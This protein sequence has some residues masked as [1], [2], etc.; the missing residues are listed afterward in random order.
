[1]IDNVAQVAYQRRIQLNEA[2]YNIVK[3][4]A[5]APDLNLWMRDSYNNLPDRSLAED[6]RKGL[7]L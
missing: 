2:P 7:G 4:A 1:M 3:E 6:L 5:K